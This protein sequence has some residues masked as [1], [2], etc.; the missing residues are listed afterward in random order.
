MA[1]L[2]LCA[3]VLLPLFS[4]ASAIDSCDN[5][6]T[7]DLH[8]QITDDESISY[9]DP[10]PVAKV[11]DHNAS[12]H[13][14]RSLGFICP[15]LATALNFTSSFPQESICNITIMIPSSMQHFINESVAFSSSV[16]LIGD[17]PVSPAKIDCSSS[18]TCY[19]TSENG[20]VNYTIFFNHST[21][22]EMTNIDITACPCPI[23]LNTVPFVA[24]VNTTMT[25]VY[26][27]TTFVIYIYNITCY[28]ICFDKR[29]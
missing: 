20:T 10:F 17:N 4:P 22:V 12:D 7:L 16:K 1:S 9:C 14:T 23:G 3:L 5:G 27:C 26:T 21:F 2:L 13:A 28:Y 11:N 24:I 15:S 6:T 25:Y 18:M 19:N 29:I 8:I